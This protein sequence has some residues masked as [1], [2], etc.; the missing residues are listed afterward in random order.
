LVANLLAAC[1]SGVASVVHN[2]CPFFSPFLPAA[3]WPH[4]IPQREDVRGEWRDITALELIMKRAEGGIGQAP[5]Y[6]R[7]R[8]IKSNV[9][10]DYTPMFAAKR[11]EQTPLDYALVPC[12]RSGSSELG[13][14]D[15]LII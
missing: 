5:L 14:T 9:T 10:P 6:V 13:Q 11:S 12:V 1:K 8:D 7:V 3:P 15:I 2:S 4:F